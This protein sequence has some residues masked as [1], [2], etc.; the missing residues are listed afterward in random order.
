MC[1]LSFY[2]LNSFED[3]KFS[4]KPTYQHFSFMNSFFGIVSKNS[5]PYPRSH[6]VFSYIFFQVYGFRF[7]RSMVLGFTTLGFSIFDSL[8]LTF[9]IKYEVCIEV[10]AF[11]CGCL[12]VPASLVENKL[13]SPLDGLCTFVKK[14]LAPFQQMML[15]N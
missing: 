12:I 10:H 1:G 2:F 3:Q 4:M 7:H 14:Q 6:R 11:A 8:E 13:L 15:S 9:Y 5:L